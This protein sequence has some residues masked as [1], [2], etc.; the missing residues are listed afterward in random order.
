[1]PFVEI[2]ISACFTSSAARDSTM[3]ES[4]HCRNFPLLSRAMPRR[5]VMVLL[6]RILLIQFIS[7]CR[8][9]GKALGD[10]FFLQRAGE[11][12]QISIHYRG[13]IVRRVA[14]AMVSNAR[15]GEII[16]TNFF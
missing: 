2:Q 13:E 16:G 15:L 7:Q 3:A 9:F 8:G 10:F 4:F 12:K 1:V 14:D 5:T 11:I 6:E